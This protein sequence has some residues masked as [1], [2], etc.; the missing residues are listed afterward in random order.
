MRCSNALFIALV[1]LSV[2]IANAMGDGYSVEYY[3]DNSCSTLAAGSG[4]ANYTSANV[5]LVLTS[6]ANVNVGGTI[7][8]FTGEGLYRIYSNSTL[9]RQ[10]L[11]YSG[12]YW[13]FA[14]NLSRIHVHG[15]RDEGESTAQLDTNA[16]NGNA[17][18][19][20]CGPTSNYASSHL[21]SIG[22]QTRFVQTLTLDPWNSYDNGHS[23][24]EIKDP[25]ENRW[26]LYDVDLGN[27]LRYGGHRLNLLDTTR[28]Y[29]GGGQAQLDVLNA[30]SVVD[31]QTDYSTWFTTAPPEAIDAFIATFDHDPQA[32]QNWYDRTFQ[33]PIID[34]YFA[35]NSDAEAARVKSYPGY[36][37]YTAL[38]P[39][40]FRQM[41]YPGEPIYYVPEPAAMTLA[42]TGSLL[43]GGFRLVRHCCL[44][45]KRTRNDSSLDCSSFRG[46]P[47]ER[48]QKRSRSYFSA[49]L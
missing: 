19:L 25:A 1:V 7:Y 18:S 49:G 15:S 27:A 39:A 34:G 17:L 14:G 23:L 41:F 11:V 37:S 43:L 42:I 4:P 5:P 48:F 32:T 35:A 20:T 24:L 31:P 29:R 21:Q 22:V 16:R 6:A 28:L 47:R 2:P 40:E 33:V 36:A 30:D 46:R 3:P 38:S 10:T 44:D 12:D 8:N 9:V 13:G 45:G 26:V